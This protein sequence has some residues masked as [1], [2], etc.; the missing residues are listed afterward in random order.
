MR[1]LPT[2]STCA[3]CAT[4][5]VFLAACSDG[6]TP[7][8]TQTATV[9]VTAPTASTG[10]TSLSALSEFAD[11]EAIRTVLA[12]HDLDCADWKSDYD[13]VQP[14]ASCTSPGMDTNWFSIDVDPNTY[15]A[16]RVRSQDTEVTGAMIGKNW[17]GECYAGTTPED[18]RRI[19]EVL[20]GEYRAV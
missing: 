15:L 11:I 16:T 5:A 2:I 19:A 14:T 8:A 10:A 1:A 17:G 7:A 20:G 3:S 6:G 9:T 18:C 4:V 12:D 13:F